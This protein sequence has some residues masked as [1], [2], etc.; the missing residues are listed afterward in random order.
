MTK[1]TLVCNHRTFCQWEGH[2]TSADVM[3]SGGCLE[4]NRDCHLPNDFPPFM[5]TLCQ[6]LPSSRKEI[7]LFKSVG[8]SLEASMPAPGKI[9]SSRLAWATH[10]GPVSKK[11]EKQWNKEMQRICVPHQLPGDSNAAHRGNTL[12]T[13]ECMVKV[14]ATGMFAKGEEY[15]YPVLMIYPPFH[16]WGWLLFLLPFTLMT[17]LWIMSG[18]TVPSLIYPLQ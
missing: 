10:R 16:P 2:P 7:L 12:L 17:P 9:L 18:D 5:H 11:N 13:H 1:K 14:A 6:H 15:S 8:F 4:R 3:A